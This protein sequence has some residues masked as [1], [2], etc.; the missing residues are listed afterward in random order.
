[1]SRS[2]NRQYI[3]NIL[4]TFL[5]QG[6]SYLIQLLI[7][8]LSL[9]YLDP[10]RYGLWLVIS[11][12]FS[13]SGLF[14]LGL[15]NGLRNRLAE[16][17][18][19]KDLELS[20]EYI[21]SA[22]FAISI[23][24][25]FFLLLFLVANQCVNWASLL[26]APAYLFR[27]FN[28]TI[29]LCVAFFFIRLIL[30]LIISILT[31]DQRIGLSRIFNFL[32]N[33]VAFIL[34]IFLKL[35]VSSSFI[36]FCLV[37]I[38]PQVLVLII[39]NTYLFK[40]RYRN[41]RPVFSKIRLRMGKDLMGLGF[42]FFII[43]IAALMIL[44]TDNIIISKVLSP[45]AVTPYNIAFKYMM[46][47]SSVFVIILQP[48]WSAFTEAHT[49]NDQEWI[50]QTIKRLIKIWLILI[51]GLFLLVVISQPIYILWIGKTVKIPNQITILMAIFAAV[52]SFNNIFINYLNGIGKINLLVTI[53]ILISILNIPLSIFN[54]KALGLGSAGVIMASIICI[55]IITVAAPIQSYV[56]LKKH[57]LN[58][59]KD[60]LQ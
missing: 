11:S 58:L 6:G 22:F 35:F 14:D 49:L 56:I 44:S 21:S 7:V 52:S 8:P 10:V 23:V 9:G 47:G 2:R 42:K 16:S 1:M 12:V 25:T 15:G 3:V 50:T 51:T 24:S 30:N 38:A 45:G 18:T 48:A 60:P 34:L 32:S 4:H 43:Q 20:Q 57:K 40:S 31:A 17:F 54:I 41:I 28:E 53:C 27:E 19:R 29:I 36:D 33:A 59:L 46:I 37:M 13:W 5:F 39:M 55:S 26:N